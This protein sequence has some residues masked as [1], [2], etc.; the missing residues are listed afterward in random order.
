MEKMIESAP[1][2]NFEVSVNLHPVKSLYR[3]QCIVFPGNC[4]EGHHNQCEKYFV[5]DNL[6][7]Y[8]LSTD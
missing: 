1:A 8:Y 7:S 6:L 2:T 5:V 4:F 3:P